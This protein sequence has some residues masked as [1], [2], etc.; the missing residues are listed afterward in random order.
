LPDSS[1]TADGLTPEPS[2]REELRAAALKGIRWT[3]LGRVAIELSLMGSMIVLAR[4]IPPAEFGPYAVAIVIQELV[5][6]VQSQGVGNAMVQRPNARRAHLQAGHAIMLVSGLALAGLTIAASHL[7]ALPIFGKP[8]ATLVALTAPFCV[9]SAL[10]IV[11]TAT[12]RRKLEFRRLTIID[13]VSSAFRVGGSIGLAVAGFGAK[14][15]IFGT[16]AGAF[17]GS[18]MAWISAPPPFPRL[19]RKATRELLDYGGPASLASVSWTCFRNCDYAIVGARV[20]TLQAGLYFRAYQLA[21]EYQKKV[22]DLMS[23]VAFP[24]L[25]RSANADD[26]SELRGKVVRLLTMLLFPLLTLLAIVAPVFIPWLLGAPWAPTVVPTQILALGGA[27]TLVIDTAGVQMAAGGR[28][29]AMLGFGVGHFAIY[30][31]AVWFVAPHGIADVAI[32]AAVVHTAFLLV[33]YVIMLWG[34]PDRPIRHLVTD[35]APAL[36]ASIALAAVAVPASLALSAAHTP[37]LAQVAVVG[38]A[39][40]GAYLVTLRACFATA[41]REL[42]SSTR[43]MLPLEKLPVIGRRPPLAGAE[44]VG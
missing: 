12:L 43:R 1:T 25:A 32:A 4:L 28:S 34:S 30:A 19:E 27:A 18:L 11:P 9:V 22:S 6:G 13:M 7:I 5:F 10:G 35:V 3:S 42:V 38:L 33:S 20:G 17:V 29:R 2:S 41:W 15:L 23:T 21:V 40:G 39:G 14:S 24:I 26:L 44:S 36:V 37:V 16:L 8:T 31:V